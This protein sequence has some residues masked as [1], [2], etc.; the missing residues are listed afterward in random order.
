MKKN[1]IQIL[2]I[3]ETKINTSCME[4]RKNYTFYFSGNEKL[5]NSKGEISKNTHAGVGIIINNE[6]LNYTEDI[7][8]INDRIMSIALSGT[9]PVTFI[10]NYTPTAKASTEEK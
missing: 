7:E 9:V 6:L 1:K 5:K 4:Q 8:P 2:A 10:C 3:Q